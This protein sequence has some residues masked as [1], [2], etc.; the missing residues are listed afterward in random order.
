[1]TL[2]G[3][4]AHATRA[5]GLLA[6]EDSFTLTARARLAAAEPTKNQTVL[7]LAGARGSALTVRYAA[8]AKRW[9][10]V[11]TD[12]DTVDARASTVNAKGTAP[13]SEGDGDHLALVYSAVFGDALLYVNGTLAAQVPWNNAWDFTTA[14]LQVGRVLTGSTPSAFFDGAVDELRMFRGALDASAVPT[15]AI[16]PAGSGVEETVT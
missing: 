9:Q 8:S 10:L 13:S 14:T 11:V 6:K 12:K 5:A 4:G 3:T 2:N 7:S 1:M 15:V 16:L